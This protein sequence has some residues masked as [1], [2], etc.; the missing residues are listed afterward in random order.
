MSTSA[1]MRPPTIPFYTRVSL[2]AL[3]LVPAQVCDHGARPL[4]KELGYLER[5]TNFSST[6][7][8]IAEISLR[9]QLHLAHQSA[10]C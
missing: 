6:I 2:F 4:T 1:I 7:Q 8:N 9:L 5:D 3:R 10:F